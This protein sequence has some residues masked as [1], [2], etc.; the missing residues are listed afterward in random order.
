[1]SREN[2]VKLLRGMGR[3]VVE[4]TSTSWS[5]VSP[6]MYMNF[7]LHRHVQPTRSEIRQVL[8][9]TGIAARYTCPL[10]W[11]RTSYTLVCSIKDYDLTSLPQKGRNRTRRGLERC[12]VRQIPFDELESLGGI[13]ITRETRLRKSR[14]IPAGH[15]DYWRK[16]FSVASKIDT[17]E[18]WGSFVEGHLAA[19]VTVSIIED[20]A[21]IWSLDSA[22][23]YLSANPNN[24]LF[25]V[26]V[27]N[28]ITRQGIVEISTGLESLQLHPGSVERFKLR[29]GFQRLPIGQ[30]VEFSPL[31]GAVLKGPLRPKLRSTLNNG[32]N[33]EYWMKLGMLLRW[34]YEQPPLESTYRQKEATL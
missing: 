24:A 26:F 27:K 20:R 30:R 34:H 13:R 25:F 10:G 8:G 5:N 14:S 33:N 2:Y 29:M 16:Y 21:Y 4:T 23:Q 15:D 17:M 22:T 3:R 7:P 9:L 28:A 18:A 19:F 1:M 12:T 31:G 32:T 11:G 6:G